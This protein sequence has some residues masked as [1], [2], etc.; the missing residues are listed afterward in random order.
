MVASHG[1]RRRR[2]RLRPRISVSVPRAHAPSHAHRFT[3]DYAFSL[4][5]YTLQMITSLCHPL[6]IYSH[7]YRKILLQQIHSIRFLP[8][9]H[10]QGRLVVLFAT[11]F[12][13]F[14]LFQIKIFS[15]MIRAS[16]KTSFVSAVFSFI[17]VNQFRLSAKLL[18][19]LATIK[20][21]LSFI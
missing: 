21:R 7:F 14:K 9:C 13:L 20:F 18:V 8:Y 3:P 12:V 10:T 11:I 4:R 5:F 16:C 1:R 6:Y 2:R 19:H 15:N 17:K